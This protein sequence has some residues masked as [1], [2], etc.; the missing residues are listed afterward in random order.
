MKN[1]Y[2]IITTEQGR[3][4]TKDVNLLPDEHRQNIVLAFES[5]RAAKK[6]AEYKEWNT[7]NVVKVEMVVV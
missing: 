6:Y 1:H 3:V 4:R 2:W 7:D 5:K